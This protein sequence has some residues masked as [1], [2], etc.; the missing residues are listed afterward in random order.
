MHLAILMT[1]TDKSAVSKGHPGDGEDFTHLV[2]LARPGWG[3]EVSSVKD[4]VFPDVPFR[5]D[6]AM[7]TGS[8]ASVHDPDAWIA[9]LPGLIR[10]LA[11]RCLPVLGAC[12]GHRPSRWHSAGRSGAIP[13]GWSTDR[14]V[15]GCC[16]GRAGHRICPSRFGSMPVKRNS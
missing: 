13:A 8:P 6:G 1:N 12:F 10:K 7:L 11:A 2:R 4:R 5:F 3:T 14:R 15:T 9:R 16:A